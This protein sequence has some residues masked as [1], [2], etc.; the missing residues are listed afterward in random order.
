[1]KLFQTKIILIT[2]STHL[3]SIR[4]SNIT[5]QISYRWSS[6][7]RYKHS[8]LRT[9]VFTWNACQFHEHSQTSRVPVS[10]L[11]NG[12]RYS[13][14]D[15]KVRRVR[16]TVSTVP[17]VFIAC[18]LIKNRGNYKNKNTKKKNSRPNET[19]FAVEWIC[20]LNELWPNGLWNCRVSCTPT[21]SG[22]LMPTSPP[23]RRRQQVPLE[24]QKPRSVTTWKRYSVRCFIWK[25]YRV[26]S[27]QTGSQKQ[28]D[29]TYMD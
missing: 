27:I 19:R 18:C 15:S 12:W 2:S 23:W 25:Q 6:P 17:H 16:E 5:E 28:P 14:A 22:K 7:Q 11:S 4:S 13:T 9:T 3:C 20:E 29:R 24:R 21:S 1:M 8:Q 10:V 26:Q